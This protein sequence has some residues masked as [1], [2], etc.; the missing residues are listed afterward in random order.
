MAMPKHIALFV[1]HAFALALG[2]VLGVYLLPIWSAPPAPSRAEV[3]QAAQGAAFGAR[4]RRD[5]PGSD[6]LHWGEGD[7]SL[8]PKGIGFSGRLSPGPAYRLYLT[9][10]FVDNADDFQRIKASSQAVGEVRTFEYFLL[11]LPEGI[12]LTGHRG[13][14]VWCEAFERFIT[15]ARYR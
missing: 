9:P 15:S 12:D 1:S 5:L 8:G 7:I 4:F 6:L 10:E 2:F 3:S 14:V 13:V 11:P